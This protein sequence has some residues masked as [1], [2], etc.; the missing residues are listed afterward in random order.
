[1]LELLEGNAQFILTQIFIVPEL[2]MQML[3]ISSVLVELLVGRKEFD[4]NDILHAASQ[5]I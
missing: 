5:C 1:M 2:L 4:G 3:Q